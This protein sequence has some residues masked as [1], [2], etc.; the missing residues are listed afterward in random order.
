MTP[1]VLFRVRWR[2]LAG[3]DIE[4]SFSTEE[5]RLYYDFVIAFTTQHSVETRLSAITR[6]K[7]L[8]SSFDDVLARAVVF[9]QGGRSDEAYQ[10]LKKAMDGGRRFVLYFP[11]SG[12]VSIK[13]DAG[14]AQRYTVNWI[15]LAS[16]RQ[17][18]S[19]EVTADQDRIRL[20]SPA[21]TGWVAV[22]L[23]EPTGGSRPQ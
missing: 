4:D 18:M 17:E 20:T 2:H 14:H 7:M 12:S 8:D 11:A 16:G 10:E 9:Y 1:A 22:L 21:E 6:L 15:D 23:A 5:L 19:S 13:L 3:L